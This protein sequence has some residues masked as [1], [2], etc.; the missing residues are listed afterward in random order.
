MAD[1][2]DKSVAAE[3][4]EVS[5]QEATLI[6]TVMEHMHPNFDVQGWKAI[7]AKVGLSVATANVPYFSWQRFAVVKNRYKEANDGLAAPAPIIKK[8]KRGSARA[9]STGGGIDGGESPL[10]RPARKRRMAGSGV[11]V[12]SLEEEDTSD[13][14]D[15]IPSNWVQKEGDDSVADQ[16]SKTSQRQATH[17]E[18]VHQAALALM[19]IRNS[20]E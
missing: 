5:S 2:N 6:M 19:A 20:K 8:R 11:T 7:A 4:F 15:N 1:I 12:P 13:D 9:D 10:A 17:D 14:G 3:T 16:K 18:E